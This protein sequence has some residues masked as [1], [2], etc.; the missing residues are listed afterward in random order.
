MKKFIGEID[1]LE[2][3]QA[4]HQ[5]G[6]HQA[7]A[8]RTQAVMAA[9]EVVRA[10]CRS[11]EGRGEPSGPQVFSFAKEAVERAFVVDDRSSAPGRA[12]SA[13]VPS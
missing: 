4:A 13:A 8:A 7:A 5:P 10:Y 3:G 12:G 9:Y 2:P 6:D 11:V 1:V